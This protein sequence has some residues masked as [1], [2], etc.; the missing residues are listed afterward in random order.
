VIEYQLPYGQCRVMQPPQAVN[1]SKIPF[2]R[3]IGFTCRAK[4][5]H[6]SADWIA[7]R[8]RNGEVTWGKLTGRI[9]E[10]LSAPVFN[11]GAPSGKRSA[12]SSAPISGKI[13]V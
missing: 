9:A 6:G 8:D 3:V 10:S 13:P 7:A 5:D 2:Y 1:F 4:I 12:T 11:E